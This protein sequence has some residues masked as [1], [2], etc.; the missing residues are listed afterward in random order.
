MTPL[1]GVALQFLPDLMRFIGPDGK[2]GVAAN[3]AKVVETVTGTNDPVLAE[4]ALADPAKAAA[5]RVE[6]ARIGAQAATEQRALELEQLRAV[7]AD[8]KDGRANERDADR[9]RLED[10]EGARSFALNLTRAG[11]PMIWG[12]LGISFIVAVAFVGILG[13]MSY[14]PDA[15]AIDPQKNAAGLQLMNITFGALTAAFATVVSFWLGSSQSSRSKDAAVF[16]LQARQQSQQDA[17]VT[18][19]NEQVERIAQQ[20]IAKT[21]G[22]APGEPAQVKRSAGERFERCVEMILKHEG[23][24]VD[25]PQDPGGA[26]NRGITFATLKAWRDQPITKQDVK[27]LTVEEAKDIYYANYWNALRCDELPD[28]VDLVVFDFG[29]NAGVGRAAKTLQ[30]SVGAGDDGVIGPVTIGAVQ[31]FK[32]DDT[33]RKFSDRRREFY[34]NLKTFGTFGKGWMARVQEVENAA[35]QMAVRSMMPGGKLALAG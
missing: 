30:R 21:E 10:T 12:S 33:V 34:R 23:G 28:G 7:L 20:A 8:R 9:T 17:M 4:R 26:T 31:K 16:E 22:G 29:V 15:F 2:G 19:Q 5:L 32:A 13:W 3:V 24:Y 1:I 11:G 35:L 14:K 25:H 6:L 18:K 27:D